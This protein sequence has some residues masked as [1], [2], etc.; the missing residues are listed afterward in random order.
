M[1]STESISKSMIGTMTYLA[2]VGP[3]VDETQCAALEEAIAESISANQIHLILDLERVSL[4]GGRFFNV[5][6]AKT[7]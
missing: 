5:T 6:Y 2:P 7:R 4:I 3:L 1:I